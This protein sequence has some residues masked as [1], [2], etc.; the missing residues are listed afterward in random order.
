MGK[1]DLNRDTSGRKHF[2]I[3][4]EQVA[5]SKISRYVW[6]GPKSTKT[7]QGNQRGQFNKKEVKSTTT[8]KKE[9]KREI[10]KRK[11]LR[12]YLFFKLYILNKQYIITRDNMEDQLTFFWL[13]TDRLLRR[14]LHFRTIALPEGNLK[15]SLS[16]PFH[17]LSRG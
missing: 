6:P 12:I 10:N 7:K 15:T 13:Q 3:G 17:Y 2:F 8:P 11:H 9:T 5:D 16:I 14:Q 4:K 1:F